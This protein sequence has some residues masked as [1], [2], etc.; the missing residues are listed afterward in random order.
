M[1]RPGWRGLLDLVTGRRWYTG[2]DCSFTGGQ[3]L[4]TAYTDRRGQMHIVS[5]ERV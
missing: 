5:L 4:A 3:V 2:I 1:R